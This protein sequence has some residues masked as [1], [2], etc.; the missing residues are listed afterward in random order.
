MG[1]A[2][3]KSHTSSERST[4]SDNDS[5]GPGIMRTTIGQLMINEALPQDLRDYSRRID[6][7]GMKALF[8]QL[9]ERHPDKYKEIAAKLMDIGQ[10]VSYSEGSSIK[11]Q[12]LKTA[13]IKKKMIPALQAEIRRI[14]ED[15]SIPPDARDEAIVKATGKLAGTLGEAVLREGLEEGNKLSEFAVSGA[16]GGAS[17][18]N[19]L[20]G[21][22][23]LVLD[24]R[25]RPIPVPILHNFS[26]GIDPAELWAASYGVRKG[27]VDLK[28]ATPKAGYFGKQLAQAAHKLIASDDK[29]LA[30]TGLPVNTD[31]PDNEGA[32]LARDYGA[33]KAGTII[34]PK[35]MKEL[36]RK[37]KRILVHSPIASISTGRGVP[38][39]AL[40]IR[41][42]GTLPDAGENVGIAAAQ[43]IS[44]PL[45]QSSSSS[46]HTAGVV[47]ATGHGSSA[48]TQAGFDVVNR[49]ANIPKEYSGKAPVTDV[50]GTVSRVEKAPQGGEFV[51]VGSHRF[52]VDPSLDTTVKAG[53]KLE[54]G[55]VLSTGVPSPADVVKHKGI[56]EG[57]RYFLEKF[58]ETLQNSGV[59]VSR[60]NSEIITRALINHIRLQDTSM[61]GSLPDDI[62][63]YDEFAA[64]YSP[65]AGSV[66]V[67]TKYAK[68]KY[69]EQPTLHYSIGTR[70]TPRVMKTLKEFDVNDVMAHDKEPDFQ[71][72][73]QRAVDVIGRDKDWMV[74]MGGF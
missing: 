39:L 18:V 19:Q 2:P 25:N 43:A 40:G 44:E 17:N 21:A 23:L 29:P 61:G 13:S 5:R 32:A 56:G 67:P 53:M 34:T 71:P 58:H 70:I 3:S 41:E 33:Y 31:D 73:M 55:D 48:E 15:G 68:G 38:R 52:H 1:T 49:L 57:R 14:V 22:G 8:K 72:E 65:R 24:H 63:E 26:E 35:V 30:G 42:R 27:Y 50:D 69:L 60:R 37:R 12:D 64:R 45:S 47:G 4:E 74:R 16:R 9:A 54:A 46:K 10:A 66:A 62:V 51:Y 7:Q 28:S 11:L 20:R 59:R 36:R 6:K